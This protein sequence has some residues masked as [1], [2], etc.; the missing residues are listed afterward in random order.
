MG[1]RA[2]LSAS[3][4]R[5]KSSGIG[6]NR[7]LLLALLIGIYVCNNMDRQVIAILAEP[8]RR[9]LDLS[10]TAIGLLTGLVFALFYTIFGIPAGWAADRIGR[11]RVIA[12]ACVVWS[13]CSA[14]GA[15]ATNFAQLALARVGV[16]IGEA[17]GTAPSFSLI[18][19]R[20]PVERRG[21]AIGLFSLGA[22]LAGLI[23]AA[24][25]GWIVPRHG[26][27]TALV[28]ISLPGVLF[29]L[30]MW[31]LMCEPRNL[32]PPAKNERPRSLTAALREF[33]LAPV[34][35]LAAIASGFSAML[36]YGFSAWLP[37]FMTRVQHM[38][39]T[40]FA[41]WYG[42]INALA[43]GMGL[44]LGGV[45]LDR[46]AAHD[47]RRHALIP[48]IG[49]LIAVPLLVAG[50][51]AEGWQASLLLLA[52]AVLFANTFLAPMLALVQNRAPADRRSLFTA[53]FLLVNNLLGAGIGP[54]IV[55]IASDAAKPYFGED[56]LRIGL[57]ALAPM[58]LVA[59]GA[60]FLL[61]RSIGRHRP[62]GAWRSRIG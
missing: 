44:T 14:L 8:I 45:L 16:G 38:D 43:F 33:L 47:E 46:L 40:A 13:G 25:C 17:G 27:R 39:M 51:L 42:P 31:L 7:W 18:A 10:D 50:A 30:L 3:Q 60:Q 11:I 59:A 56:A 41:L 9:D 55:G 54:L 34:L 22:P 29:A 61:A 4:E 36:T 26:W 28:V 32:E 23:A 15:L 52:P 1:A 21:F 48:C 49:F 53:T 58:A 6:H 57:L 24:A 12:V 5:K 19:A 35:P 37:T 20:F 2:S 62:S